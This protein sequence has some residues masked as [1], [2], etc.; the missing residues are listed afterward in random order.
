VIGELDSCCCKL[1]FYRSKINPAWN[2]NGIRLR[3]SFVGYYVVG[4]NVILMK[5]DLVETMTFRL[6]LNSL[7]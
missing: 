3:E 1:Y 5:V 7:S 2:A 4:Y 6:T